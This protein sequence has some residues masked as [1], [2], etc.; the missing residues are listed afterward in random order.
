[1]P[2][3][4]TVNKVL[5]QAFAKAH[6]RG[7][8]ASDRASAGDDVIAELTRNVFL[9]ETQKIGTREAMAQQMLATDKMSEKILDARAASSQPNFAPA[10][11]SAAGAG[12]PGATS[13]S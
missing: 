4:D 3:D 13:G 12:A 7:L 2:I 9:G 1:M 10:G 11:G 8:Q 6:Q 5:D